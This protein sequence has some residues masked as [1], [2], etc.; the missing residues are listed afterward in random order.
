MLTSVSLLG[1]FLVLSCVNFYPLSLIVM[2]LSVLGIVFFT[3]LYIIFWENI[4]WAFY[5]GEFNLMQHRRTTVFG[6]LLREQS[7]ESF[8]CWELVF[9]I[10]ALS[11]SS[12]M[13]LFFNPYGSWW[14]SLP[15]WSLSSL[16]S[17]YSNRKLDRRSSSSSHRAR[18]HPSEREA[19]LAK[20]SN[21]GPQSYLL[22][23]K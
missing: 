3:S 17:R 7:C 8:L 4:S 19:I 16:M 22:N 21:S 6:T 11:S 15:L 13:Q 1:W 5:P 2:N 10:Q 23:L 14:E 9:S 18:H 12:L 20:E